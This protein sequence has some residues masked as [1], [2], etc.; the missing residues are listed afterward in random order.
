MESNSRV[1]VSNPSASKKAT[2]IA[3]AIT[4][5]PSAINER[6]FR[7]AALAVVALQLGLLCPAHGA[8]EVTG[9]PARSAQLETALTRLEGREDAKY[10]KGAIEQAR[11]ALDT[12]SAQGADDSTVARACGI[13]HA[14]IVLAERQLDRREAQ[15]R[16]FAVQRRLHA[17]RARASAQRRALEALM[18]ER[19]S[20]AREMEE[21]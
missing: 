21:P 5:S 2:S 18:R 19:A 14:A 8:A 4:S 1:N 12:A 15:A 11:R 7:P 3:S 9:A 20:L 10:A 13:A 6:L 16:L 17:I